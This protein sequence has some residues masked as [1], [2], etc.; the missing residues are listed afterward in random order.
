MRTWIARLLGQTVDQPSVCR[1]LP[2]FRP[3]CE[4]LEAR[5]VPATL[6]W[7]G[8]Y[9]GSIDARVAYNWSADGGATRSPLLPTAGDDIFFDG[10]VSNVSSDNFSFPAGP[11][12]STLDDPG[13]TS[14]DGWLNSVHL[15]HGYIGGVTY[16]L[17]LLTHVLEMQN[18]GLNPASGGLDVTVNNAF[19]WDPQDPDNPSGP[20]GDPTLNG[21]AYPATLHL[22]GAT[23]TIDP[24]DSDMLTGDTLSFESGSAGDFEPG[25]V[26]FNNAASILISAST[27]LM[28][29]A[30]GRPAILREGNLSV[31]GIIW[32]KDTTAKLTISGK[33]QFAGPPV[34]LDD[35]L[36]LLNDG[37]TVKLTRGV[38]G[39]FYGQQ[40]A[41]GSIEPYT[42]SG[43]TTYIQNGSTIEVWMPG[44]AGQPMTAGTVYIQGGYLM[45]AYYN[46][47]TANQQSAQITGSLQVDNS[48]VWIGATS[49][50]TVSNVL[51]VTEDVNWAGG[52]YAASVDGSGAASL[53]KSAKTFT[54][55]AANVSF[56]PTV[57]TNQPAVNQALPVIRGRTVVANAAPPTNSSDWTA[58]LVN[59]PVTEIDLKYKAT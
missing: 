53:W 10:T 24:R 41:T 7:L 50:S 31:A 56:M 6:T 19:T 58:L 35:R 54:I 42:Q 40:L 39:I 11:G 30:A 12:G 21:T 51:N 28:N 5:D 49:P 14:G 38:T 4:P 18:G 20:L 15:V 16:S 25:T 26:D 48:I 8:G 46:V 52:K 57:G 17:P 9:N 45:T 34:Y 36:P 23:A 22:V 1:P 44:R 37:G 33:D 3:A 13:G 43:G 47:L 27:V 32:L 2:R 59:N 55:A 29:P